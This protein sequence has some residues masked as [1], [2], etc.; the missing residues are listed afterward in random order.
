MKVKTVEAGLHHFLALTTAGELFAWGDNSQ[1]Q[2]GLDDPDSCVPPNHFDK[3]PIKLSTADKPAAD[4][5][6]GNNSNMSIK[7]SQY[8]GSMAESIYTA[9]EDSYEVIWELLEG[10]NPQ[11]PASMTSEGPRIDF[12]QQTRATQKM[13]SAPNQNWWKKILKFSKTPFKVH[14]DKQSSFGA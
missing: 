9:D 7:T 5:A 13:R 1:C 4:G 12:Q 3:S 11:K 8:Q 6:K 14:T 10:S 2:L